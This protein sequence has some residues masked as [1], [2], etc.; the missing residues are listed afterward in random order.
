MRMRRGIC[1]DAVAGQ[2]RIPKPLQKTPMITHLDRSTD[3]V[4]GF[5]L[6]GTLHDSDY[7]ELV[8]KLDSAIEKLG[9][10]RLLAW[11]AEDFAGWDAAA[12]WDDIKFSANH[13]SK[14]GRIAL[15]G[16]KTW[17]KYMAKVCKPF[18][19]AT[20]KYFDASEVDSA[21]AWVKEDQ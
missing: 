11:F 14:V 6:S 17:E 20:V 5:K 1:I 19:A 16:D 4:I 7:N 15:V 3:S 13:F 18:T 10:I 12:L 9:Q 2:P 21:W 8:P